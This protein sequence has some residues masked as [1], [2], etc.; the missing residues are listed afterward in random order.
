[1]KQKT[2][3]KKTISAQ[4]EADKLY[5]KALNSAFKKLSTR[6]KN[7]CHDGR[8]E[9]MKLQAE[10][11]KKTNCLLPD[12]LLTRQETFDSFQDGIKRYFE[13]LEKERAA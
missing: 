4:E 12:H 1:M 11:I 10:F 5:Q 9:A 2:K 6:V 13:E 3:T 8:L 7:F